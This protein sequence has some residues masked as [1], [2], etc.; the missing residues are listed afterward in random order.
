MQGQQHGKPL[1]L[2][3]MSHGALVAGSGEKGVQGE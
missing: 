3:G 2:P 1:L